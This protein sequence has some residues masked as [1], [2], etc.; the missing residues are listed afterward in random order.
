M[1]ATYYQSFHLEM[2][3]VAPHT[4]IKNQLCHNIYAALSGY[5]NA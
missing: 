3:S 1:F 2:V 4:H 5:E